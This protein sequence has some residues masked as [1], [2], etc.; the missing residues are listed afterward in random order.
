MREEIIYHRQHQ[1]KM[2]S[3]N[4]MDKMTWGTPLA[5]ICTSAGELFPEP[6]R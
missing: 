4:A 1:L 3:S 5:H 6:A 2:V